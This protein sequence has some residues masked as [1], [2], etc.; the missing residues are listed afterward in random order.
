MKRVHLLLSAT[1]SLGA[2][3]AIP[4]TSQAQC[5]E[6]CVLVRDET[7]PIGH[8]CFA[9]TAGHG[10]VATVWECTINSADCGDETLVDNVVLDEDGR[11]AATAVVCLSAKQV[12]KLA[13]VASNASAARSVTLRRA[14]ASSGGPQVDRASMLRSESARR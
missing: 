1:L 13:V 4:A 2:M 3:S 9:G 7:G 6:K 11:Q 12:V 8:G 10:C 14:T 5:V